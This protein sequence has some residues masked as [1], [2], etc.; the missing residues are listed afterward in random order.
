[1]TLTEFKKINKTA[2]KLN[3]HSNGHKVYVFNANSVTPQ[4]TPI[5]RVRSV[6]EKGVYVDEFIIDK[7]KKQLVFT[8]VTKYRYYKPTYIVVLDTELDDYFFKGLLKYENDCKSML[9][10]I[11]QHLKELDATAIKKAREAVKDERNAL[12]E[13]SKEIKKLFT[14]T[15]LNNIKRGENNE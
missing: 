3:K 4:I 12:Q 7:D 11:Q 13:E 2:D 14:E 9:N 6:T 8:G 10:K 1:M 15:L 5:G